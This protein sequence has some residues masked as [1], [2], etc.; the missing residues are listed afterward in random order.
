MTQWA[1]AHIS[2]LMT[3]TQTLLEEIDTFLA[4][5]KMAESTF[6]RKAVNDGKLVARL[7]AGKSITLDS[8]DAVRGFMLNESEDREVRRTPTPTPEPAS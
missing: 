5:S 3:A 8:A 2:V 6:G 7:R 4:S 1:K